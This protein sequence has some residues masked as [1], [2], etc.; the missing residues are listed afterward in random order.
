MIQ[1]IAGCMAFHSKFLKTKIEVQDVISPLSLDENSI[2]STPWTR[3][4]VKNTRKL[5]WY[6]NGVLTVRI[7]SKIQGQNLPS[8][9]TAFKEVRIGRSRPMKGR[10]TINGHD[11]ALF[12]QNGAIISHSSDQKSKIRMCP[13]YAL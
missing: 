6:L 11:E 8:R 10:I 4:R 5:N 1:L 7:L 12:D 2:S 9:R 13:R 3:K